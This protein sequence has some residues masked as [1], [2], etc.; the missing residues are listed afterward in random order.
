MPIYTKF[1]DKGNTALLGGKVVQKD[2]VQVAAYGEVDELNAMLGIV[3]SFNSD[4]KEIN[5][6]LKKVQKDLFI[7]GAKLAAS[8]SEVKTPALKLTRVEEMEKTIDKMEEQLIPLRNF[9]LPGGTKLAAL[10]H[11]TRTVCRR[12]ERAIVAFSNKNKVNLEVIK[13]INRLSDML[14]V[15]ARLA[16]RKKRVEETIWKS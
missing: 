12:A 6:E 16:N 10:L 2:D 4:I 5:E 14:F 8:N 7:I 1:G 3:I 13:Y 9:I 15:M 11:H